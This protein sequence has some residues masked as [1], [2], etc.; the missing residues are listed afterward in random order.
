MQTQRERSQDKDELKNPT[1][2]Y[3]SVK[4]YATPK[5]ARLLRSCTHLF[6]FDLFCLAS[7]WK[8][9]RI[10]LKADEMSKIRAHFSQLLLSN[11]VILVASLRS[12][13][14]ESNVRGLF[15]WK[16]TADGAFGGQNLPKEIIEIENVS[17]CII[18]SVMD[19]ELIEQNV[20]K[21]K[22]S[23]HHPDLFHNFPTQLNLPHDQEWSSFSLAVLLAAPHPPPPRRS[24]PPNP[25]PQLEVKSCCSSHLSS[26]A[27][28]PLSH[29]CC[30]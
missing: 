26:S 11:F 7:A 16:E 19:D 3:V 12:L 28:F 20:T 23:S 22:S 29:Y 10:H 27:T 17:I 15:D 14:E 1:L 9:V 5:T 2:H 13:F 6:W 25:W 18:I 30:A 21:K 8:D 24:F 4:L